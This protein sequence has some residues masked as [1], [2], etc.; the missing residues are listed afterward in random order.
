MKPML[1]QTTVINIHVDDVGALLA[2]L[3]HTATHCY[4]FAATHQQHFL[5]TV[6]CQRHFATV[7]WLVLR[8]T[9][10]ST[11]VS[12]YWN[13]DST[14]VFFPKV[15]YKRRDCQIPTACPPQC[16]WP[17]LMTTL[18]QRNKQ[19]D[20]TIACNEDKKLCY[21]RWTSWHDVSVKILPTAA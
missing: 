2:C 14:S 6:N 15:A 12:P 20:R 9:Q 17:W 1:Q 21:R 8:S 5:R 4:I 11:L 18:W 3:R 16:R 10:T 13:H 19:M 7:T